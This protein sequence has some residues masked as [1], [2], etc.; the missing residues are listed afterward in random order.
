[1]TLEHFD[2]KYI[3]RKSISLLYL[4]VELKIFLAEVM[5]K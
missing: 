1:M 3:L 5:G 4:S 2:D